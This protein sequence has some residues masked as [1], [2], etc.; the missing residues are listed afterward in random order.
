MTRARLL[1]ACAAVLALACTRRGDRY[2]D[3]AAPVARDSLARAGRASAGSATAPAAAPALV[4]PAT[5]LGELPCA[6]CAGRRTILTLRTD[7]TFVM[8]T[9]YEG[10][11]EAPHLDLGR[12]SVDPG[13]RRLVL[14][15]GTEAPRLLAV[16]SAD[17]LRVLDDRGR[18]I[19]TPMSNDLV[20]AAAVEQIHDRMR[21]RGSFVQMA[22]VASLTECLTGKRLP[23]TQKGDYAAVERAYASGRSAPGAPL[24]V[25]FDGHFVTRPR[26]EGGG[27]EEAI[28]V[29]RFD[30]AWPGASC[31]GGSGGAAVARDS[32]PPGAAAIVGPEW[33]L[34]ELDG[35]P[36]APDASGRAPTLLLTADGT[37]ASGFA[38]CN[39]MTGRYELSGD[40]LRL[41]PV[42]TTRMACPPPMM[43][44]EQAYTAALAATRRYRVRGTTLELLDG[45][46]KVRARLTSAGR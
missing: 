21:L 10:R 14:R 22:D 13:G 38:G 19:P 26:A 2:G 7:S 9:V 18:E 37:R 23:V 32:V 5:Y 43:Q 11:S 3:S 4:V 35:R 16:R 45:D 31:E 6:D 1:C 42:A 24:L 27:E 29:D 20:R 36:V 8:R 30:R 15:G 28:A 41:G 12:W 44:T 25:T 40:S 33:T 46:G 17:T 34:V 39:R